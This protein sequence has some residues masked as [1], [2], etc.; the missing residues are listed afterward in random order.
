MQP[1]FEPGALAALH[2]LTHG[3]ARSINRLCDLSLLIGFAE[4]RRTIT[5][6][7][8]EAVCEELVTVAPE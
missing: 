8:I 2:D 1:I 3:V 7:N 6:E 4:E 5:G